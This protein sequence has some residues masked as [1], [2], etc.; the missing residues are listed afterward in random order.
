M[1]KFVEFDL[2]LDGVKLHVKE[3]DSFNLPQVDLNI[4]YDGVFL[5][6]YSTISQ[7]SEKL[8]EYK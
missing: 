1:R 8:K 4:Y 2:F 5:Y 3:V 6:R 7:E